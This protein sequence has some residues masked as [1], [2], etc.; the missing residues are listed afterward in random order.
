MQM[1][2]NLSTARQR[3]VGVILPGTTVGALVHAVGVG[4]ACLVSY[5]L[6]TGLLSDVHSISSAD[7]ALG[8]MWAVIATVFV[9]RITY[10]QSVGAALS[11]L[12]ATAVS[13][14]LCLIYLLIFSFHPV[15]LAVLI[16][17]G[18]FLLMV[19]RRDDLV[20]TTGITTT[21]VLVV[22]FLSPHDA[23]QQPIL[24]LVD[25]LIGVGIGIVAA[26]L[27]LRVSSSRAHGTQISPTNTTTA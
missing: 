10:Q 11:R 18:T 9:Y 4:I 7:D 3:T 12:A 23:W 22:A 25:T 20:V 13:F 2:H 1:T 8:G 17:I 24:R 15:G 16:A 26:T 21:V 6:V 14:A 27:G 5:L 19:T